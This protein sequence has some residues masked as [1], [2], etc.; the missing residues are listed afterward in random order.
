M[1]FYVPGKSLNTEIV[2]PGGSRGGNMDF[3]EHPIK[4]SSKNFKLMIIVDSLWMSA[5]RI[6]IF[7]KIKTKQLQNPLDSN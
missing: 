3:T 1:K 4:M 2:F 5:G 6:Y 7:V